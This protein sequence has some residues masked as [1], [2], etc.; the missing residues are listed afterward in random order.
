MQQR[1]FLQATDVAA[2][3]EQSLRIELPL[4]FP[5]EREGR[6]R[7][8]PD[9]DAAL[10]FG[11]RR[12]QH[13]MAVILAASAWSRPKRCAAGVCVL[14]ASQSVPAPTSATS[15]VPR[16][17]MVFVRAAI[18]ARGTVRRKIKRSGARGKL[19]IRSR[20]WRGHGRPRFPSRRQLP[21]PSPPSHAD[22]AP[23]SVRILHSEC[24]GATLFPWNR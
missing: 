1:L 24:P 14:S 23:L 17:S 4:D 3:I 2:G 21:A 8:A 11:G 19:S 12:E 7:G 10:E 13:D 9:L 18:A 6:R 22:N 5:Q 15:A 20:N 16:S